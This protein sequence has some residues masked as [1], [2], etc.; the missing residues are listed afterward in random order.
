MLIFSYQVDNPLHPHHGTLLGRWSY[1]YGR[2]E[3]EIEL[4]W[5]EGISNVRAIITVVYI[6]T[7]GYTV[8]CEDEASDKELVG[9]NT[10]NILL[11]FCVLQAGVSLMRTAR[12]RP[13][14]T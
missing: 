2:I 1:G 4:Q 11:G 12:L 10:A 9:I 3:I 13:Q 8:V 6:C 7:H 14:K 5:N